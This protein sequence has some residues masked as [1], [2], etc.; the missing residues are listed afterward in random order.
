MFALLAAIFLKHCVV[1][2]YLVC[3]RVKVSQDARYKEKTCHF[4]IHKTSS[5]ISADQTICASDCLTVK[6]SQNNNRLTHFSCMPTCSTGFTS[7]RH[8]RV[9]VPELITENLLFHFLFVIVVYE[10]P[11]QDTK[12]LICHNFFNIIS[13][14]RS[15]THT[16]FSSIH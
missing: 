16:L 10:K 5:L 13:N 6:V 7:R 14:H 3:S 2:D 8:P 9:F 4:A 15:H 11:S 1:E 12:H